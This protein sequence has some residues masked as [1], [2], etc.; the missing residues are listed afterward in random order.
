ME[1]G[2][3]LY[4]MKRTALSEEQ[5]ARE[6]G[7]A[8]ETP[9]GRSIIGQTILE[10]FKRGF[11]C[12]KKWPRNKSIYMLEHPKTTST[13][14][15]KN[16]VDTTMDNQ[17]GRP[18]IRNPQRL[19]DRHSKMS[20]DTV[21][22]AAKSVE[23]IRNVLAC[24]FKNT[25]NKSR[26]YIAIG[27]QV[28]YVDHLPTGA[29][30]WYDLDPQ[31]TAVVVGARGGVP[32]QEI[33]RTRVTLDPIVI[34]VWPKVHVLDAATARFDI[35]NREQIRAQH[36]MAKQEDTKVL[37]AIH[38][39]SLSATDR[40]PQT[41]TSTGLDRGSLATAFSYVESLDIPVANVVMHARQLRDIRAWTNRDF[42]PVSQRELV[43]T[44][45]VGD[46]WNAQV[47]ISRQQT[48]GTVNVLGD[49]Q[50]LGVISVRVDLSQMDWWCSPFKTLLYAGNLKRRKK[51]RQGNQQGRLRETK[52]PQ[53]LDKH[54]FNN[55]NITKFACVFQMN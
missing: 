5:V 18:E 20:E 23:L 1:K 7:A 47:R 22:T 12:N 36:E 42:D 49:P 35:L 37:N 48:I 33:T 28:M 25:S 41:T 15:S 6:V 38:Y 8:M 3:Y 9:Q 50:F 39:S 43:K 45:Y 51:I 10:P 21:R 54:K 29:P 52:S 4:I 24:V 27:R 19:H 2:D 44:G 53:R 11:F 13:D 40:N 14:N 32:Y 17:Q 46:I 34:A 30:M 16:L 31:F 26:D 55:K